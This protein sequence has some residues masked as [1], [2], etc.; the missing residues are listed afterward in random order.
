MPG[1]VGVIT[2]MPRPR[3]EELVRRMLA[4]VHHEPF[5]ENRLSIDEDRGVYVGCCT[6]APSSLAR[7]MPQHN[8][9]GDMLAFSGEDFS[10]PG[11]GRTSLLARAV[12]EPD[13]PASI[14]GRFHGLLVRGRDEG[15][16]LFNDRYGLHRIYYHEGSDGL[17]FAAE[18]K[19]ILEVCPELADLDPEG[20]AEFI[21]CGCVL[22]NRSLFKR[23]HILPPGSAWLCRDGKVERKDSYFRAA[24]WEQQPPLEPEAY[25][26]LLRQRFATSL[27]RYFSGPG[28][29]A[30]S[31]TGGFDTRIIMAWEQSAP[32]TLPCYTFGGATRI[33]HDVRVA[34]QV[35]VL[36]D[37]PHHVI[38]VGAEFL[39]R[40]SHYAER[41]IYLT[42]GCADVSRSADLY[43][44]EIARRV[45]PVRMTGNYGSEVL[46]RVR[47]FKPVALM[48]ELFAPELSACLPRAAR[49]YRSLVRGHPLSFAV[50]R[51]APWHHYGLLALEESQLSVRTPY[52]DNEFVATLYRAPEHAAGGPDVS[53]RLIADG[54]PRLLD[55]ETDRAVRPRHPTVSSLARAVREFSFKAEYAYDYGMPRWLARI[56]HALAPLRLERLFLGR[57]KF[58]HFRVWYRDALARYVRD[59]LLDA[60]TLSRPYLQR[61]TVESIVNGHLRGGRNHTLEIHRL[62][63]LELFHRLF[64][65][66]RPARQPA[67]VLIH[68]S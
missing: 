47:A 40:F 11:G 14:N 46:R 45:A 60:T 68:A 58:Y 1:L 52:L 27:P 51:Q 49:T 48:P 3:A 20:L 4:A 15:A 8:A 10:K 54:D 16:V 2:K 30:V 64:V 67:G 50:F 6:R 28:R 13:F 62:L 34:R 39:E 23:I 59:T 55:V 22:E 12:D 18:A 53:V 44:N 29:V 36:R 41:T 57:H 66:R 25:Y 63:T 21:S 37:Q 17:Y 9:A 5:Y 33:S 32:G 31:L 35:A 65:D 26:E 42:D 38:P 61:R 19:A 7:P 56:D 24:D 43:V